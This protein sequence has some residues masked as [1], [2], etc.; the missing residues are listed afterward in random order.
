M[1][2]IYQLGGLF[3]S[4]F[5]SATLLPGTSE[6]A[7]VAVLTLGTSGVVIAVIVATVGNVLGSTINWGMG[8][9]AAQYRDRKWFPGGSQM[10]RAETWYQ[11][12]GV[13]SLFM[14]WVPL[15]GDPLTLVAG[16]MRSPLWLVV[17]IVAIA[18]GARYIAVASAVGWV[19]G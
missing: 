19:A 5:V 1:D 9:F 11:K 15:L 4:A 12:Y 6:A 3:L 16:L 14:S 8:R 18:K 17:P 2:E 13:W 10:A 7:L